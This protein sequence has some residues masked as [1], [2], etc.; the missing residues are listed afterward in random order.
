MAMA[1]R[2]GTRR[3]CDPCSVRKVRCD[4]NQPCAR[5]EAAKWDCTYL[6]THGK[7]GPKGPRRTTEAAI[8]RLQERSKTGCDR[9]RSASETSI[10]TGSPVDE[11]PYISPMPPLG[12][13]STYSN[14]WPDVM[15]PTLSSTPQEPQRIPVACLS[16][17]LEIYQARGY[18]IWPVVDA[19]TLTARLLTHPHDVEAYALATAICA[20]IVSQFSIDV[21]PGSP[22]EGPYRV[23]SGAFESEARRARDESDH[24]ENI[25]MSSL[26]GSFFLHVYSANVGRMNAS[27]VLLGEAIF[28][29][30]VLGL[31]NPTHYQIMN[32]EQ[33]QYALRVYWL[34]FITERA[35]SLQH[36]VPTTLKRSPDLPSLQDLRDGSVTPAFVQLCRLFN[37]L[38]VTITADPASARRALAVAQHQLSSDEDPRSLENELQRAD[39][40][41]TQQWMRIFLWQHALNVTNLSSQPSQDE[42]FSFRFP[43]RVAQNVLSNLS[44][45]SRESVE[46]HGPGM[47]SKL[48]DVANSLADV[49][50]IMPSLNH[51]SHFDIG[52]RDLMHSLSQV[53]AGFRGGNPAVINILQEKL[54]ALGLSVGSPQRLLELSS[55]E[56]EQ[57]EYQPR[58]MRGS[59]PYGP[60]ANDP[61]IMS[62]LPPPMSMNGRY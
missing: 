43:A 58:P 6:K 36:D 9:S 25:T 12:E 53:L 37:I 4:G 45:L 50:M 40:T 48:F 28:K 41:M 61:P 55:P 19:E 39:I 52:P 7:S 8:R 15:S 32:A 60:L 27:T 1:P 26:L 3:A 13:P 14:G 16:Q 24:L 51:E 11:L 44:S 42:E 17:Y 10:D 30:H 54:T 5:C 46:A 56:E 47:E 38:D 34:L 62:P 59:S 20:A 2:K 31:H 22:V 23:S 49:M 21:E 33:T 29:A 18:G 35:H 57:D